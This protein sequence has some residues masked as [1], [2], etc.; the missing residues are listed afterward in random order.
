[1]TKNKR[2]KILLFCAGLFVFALILF[3]ISHIGSVEKEEKITIGFIMTGRSDESGWNRT[4]YDAIKQACDSAGVELK[5]KEN[6]REFTGQCPEAVEELVAEGAK[7][8]ILSSYG[9]PE[10]VKDMIEK[11]PDIVFYSNSAEYH[12]DNLTTYFV[13]MYQARYL[14]GIIAGMQTKSGEIGYVAA[15][16]NSEVNRGINAFTLGVR[17]VNP[18][19]KVIVTWTDTWEDKDR[20]TAAAETLI[21]NTDIDVITY[22]QNQPYVIEAAENAGIDSI[23]YHEVAAGC[24]EHYLTSVVC[25]WESTYLKI[26]NRFL[27]GK[28]SEDGLYW[29]GMQEGVVKLSEY[30]DIVSEEAK[31]EVKQAESEIM[32]GKDVFNGVI[33]DNEGNLRCNENETLSDEMLFERFDWFV[34]GV[35]VYEK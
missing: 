15:M 35:V 4:H 30:S 7:M 14:A 11:Y 12:S 18:Q 31:Q 34:E 10:E 13:R 1:M 28:G 25:D 2:M 27:Q 32:E 20:E 21:N 19:A 9:Y 26:I 8:I 3:I 16:S 33:Y 24:S 29:M 5:V 22:H 23:G 17:R 6:I